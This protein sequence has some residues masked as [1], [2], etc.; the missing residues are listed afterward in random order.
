MRAT[1]CAHATE[2]RGMHRAS[3]LAAVA[4][5]CSL[6]RHTCA[7]SSVVNL[8][9]ELFRL[10]LRGGLP[11]RAHAASSVCKTGKAGSLH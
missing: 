2:C 10:L 9:Q 4:L 5:A 11:I 6:L 7:E 8:Q 3:C 1:A